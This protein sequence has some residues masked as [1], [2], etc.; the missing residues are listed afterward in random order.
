MR[1][2]DFLPAGFPNLYMNNPG[3]MYDMFDNSFYSKYLF[4]YVE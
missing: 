4:K 3:L 2:A 1:A